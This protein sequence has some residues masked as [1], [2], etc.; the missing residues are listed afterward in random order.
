MAAAG[1]CH[2]DL[3]VRDGEWEREGPIVLGHEGSAVVEALGRGRRRRV[4]RACGPASSSRRLADP[5]RPVPRLPGG[6]GVE[7]LGEPVLHPPDAERPRGHAPAGDGGGDVLTY[8]AIGT[9]ADRQNVPAAA[10][11]PMPDGRRPRW[12]R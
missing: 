11:I 7:L 1:V 6:P 5:V 9:F 8:C 12:P 2:S 3:H 10:A 4:S